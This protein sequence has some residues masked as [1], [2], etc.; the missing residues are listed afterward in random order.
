MIIKQ[1]ENCLCTRAAVRPPEIQLKIQ[2]K[3]SLQVVLHVTFRKCM[4]YMGLFLYIAKFTNIFINV[5]TR[6]GTR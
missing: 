3:R 5:L 4:R 2:W 1:I 6:W